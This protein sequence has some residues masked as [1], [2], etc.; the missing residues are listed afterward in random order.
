[1][2][3]RLGRVLHWGLIAFAIVCALVGASNLH[4]ASNIIPDQPSSGGWETTQE[5]IDWM[6]KTGEKFIAYAFAAFIAGRAVRYV[7][8][9][10]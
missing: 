6:Q 9:G 8:A 4:S 2:L 1:M 5:L 7:L 3:A 10:E